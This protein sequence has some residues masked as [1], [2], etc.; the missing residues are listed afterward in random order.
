MKAQDLKK[1]I[2]Q[3]A[4]QGKLVEQ[5]PNDEPATVL[6]ERIKAEKAAFVKAGKIK[7]DK[8]TSFIYKTS[9]GYFHENINGVDKDISD[10]LPFDIPDS[11][12]WVRL[13]NI[14]DTYTGNSISEA[15][16][17]KKYTGLKEGFNYIG[18]KDVSF[19][20]EIDYENGIKIPFSET[21]FKHAFPHAI[22]MCIEGGSAGRK[23]AL[24]NKEV[25]FGNKLCAF[26]PFIIP[27]EYIYIFLQTPYFLTIFKENLSGIIG[28]VSINKIKEL[29]VPLPPLAEQKRI[30]AK[31][32]ELEPLIA[33]YD[34]A[35]TALTAL[36]TAFPEQMKKSILQQA[37]QGKL[38]E[39]DPNDESATVLLE[40]I[41]AEKAALV[42][43]GKIKKD[44]VTSFIYKSPDDTFHENANGVDK[45][46]S[47]ELPFDIPDS[48]TWVRLKEICQINPKNSFDDNKETSFIPMALIKEGF[49]SECSFE[50]KIW[51][52]IKKGFTHF[53]DNDIGIAKIT[54]CFQNRK[55]AVFRGLLNGIGA[56]TTELHVLRGN[57]AFI[58]PYYILWF[59]KNESFIND[60][61]KHFTGT[62]GQQRISK[63]FIENTLFPLPPLAEQKRIV[64][65]IEELM[66]LNFI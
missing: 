48:W 22:L 37:I 44:K 31:I 38:V 54:P 18:T 62:A 65:K 33:E 12:M 34:T 45:D 57:V 13:K 20:H 51:R 28:G 53:A 36:N 63:D 47:G 40:R 49:V 4:I 2:L 58:D 21:T 64:A 5:D 9:D 26:H 60:G 32:E 41:K 50:T 59:L 39:Q 61:I 35:E 25:C 66:L 11:W 6:L 42:K 29:L 17:N 24:L 7:K 27:S 16:K 30:V 15:E 55:S 46:I 43:A 3:L 23:I 52:N 19:S 10:E 14:S 1:S 8:V 56:G